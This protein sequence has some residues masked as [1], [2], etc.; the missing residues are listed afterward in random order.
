MRLGQMSTE[1]SQRLG[2]LLHLVR[3]E[4]GLTLKEAAERAGMSFSYLSQLE[5]GGRV[6]SRESIATLARAY[7]ID[8]ELL[9]R[10]AGHQLKPAIT[11]PPERIH[12]AFGTACRDCN[13]HYGLQMLMRPLSLAEEALWVEFYQESTGRQL[14]K[15]SEEEGVRAFLGADPHLSPEREKGVW[16]SFQDI[17]KEAHHDCPQYAQADVARSVLLA[18]IDGYV[19]TWGAK[20]ETIPNLDPDNCEDESIEVDLSEPDKKQPKP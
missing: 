6:P 10:E 14:L 17:V 7:G 3:N 19:K 9:L 4:Q 18:I 13:H 1:Q 15:A 20:P 12:W 16:V 5:R 2:A 8:E 11:I